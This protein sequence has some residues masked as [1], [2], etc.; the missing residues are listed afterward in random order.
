[1]Q[2]GT[3]Q[4]CQAGDLQSTAALS[5]IASRPRTTGRHHASHHEGLANRVEVGGVHKAILCYEAMG[6]V[7]G[8]T[9]ILADL[10]R[11]R[12]ASRDE[13]VVTGGS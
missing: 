11:T 1:M 13:H 4:V 12:S 9:G 7:G 5:A 10:P 3:V 6:G 2:R 8:V